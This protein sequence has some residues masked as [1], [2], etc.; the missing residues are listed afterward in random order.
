MKNEELK[1]KKET[2]KENSNAGFWKL[3]IEIEYQKN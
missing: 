2:V 3:D 1:M